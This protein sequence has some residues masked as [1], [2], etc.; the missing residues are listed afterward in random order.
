[1]LRQHYNST[2]QRVELNFF[3]LALLTMRSRYSGIFTP[4][5][6]GVRFAIVA[7]DY[8]TKWAKVEALVNITI[9]CIETFLWKNVVC[10]Y[11]IPY[12]FV[13]D[14]GKQFNCDSF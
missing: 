10:H 8:F 6:G 9:K 5:K 7:V 4:R 2:P 13:M 1:M 3:T 12:A 11:G 14:N